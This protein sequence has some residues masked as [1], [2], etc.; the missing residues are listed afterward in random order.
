MSEESYGDKLIRAHDMGIG[1]G[2]FPYGWE[3]SPAEAY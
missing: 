1:A 3:K 2:G